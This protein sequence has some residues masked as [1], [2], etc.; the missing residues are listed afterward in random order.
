MDG[1]L[2]FEERL[3]FDATRDAVDDIVACLRAHGVAK[4]SRIYEPALVAAI[5]ASAKKIYK[6]R[7][8][9]A[10]MGTLPEGLQDLHGNLRSIALTDLTVPQADLRQV[11]VTEF[12][13]DVGERFMGKPVSVHDWS[14]ARCARAKHNVLQLPFHQDMR[15]L[16]VPLVNVW[17]PLSACGVEIPGLEVV[18]RPLSDLE[19]TIHEGENFYAGI[20]VEIAADHVLEKFGLKSLWHPAFVPG[21]ALIF[22]GTT[23]HRT[24]VTP[25]MQRE[26]V[27]IDMRLV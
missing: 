26:R 20:G 27:S 10:A 2:E 13:R 12:V 21:D 6:E 22:Q 24:H 11:L 1:R 8:F 3:E 14:Y 15:L 7:D 4:V 17:I 16:G 5:G 23:I 19:D 25:A 18:A 9:A